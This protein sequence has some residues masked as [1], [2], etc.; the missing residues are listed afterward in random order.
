MKLFGKKATTHFMRHTH[1]SLL[2]EQGIPFDAIARRLGHTNS[3]IT[4]DIYFHVTKKLRE[5][6]NLALQKVKIL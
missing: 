1:V 4:K 5:K 3:K 6:D 2:A